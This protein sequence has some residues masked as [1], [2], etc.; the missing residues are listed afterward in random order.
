MDT[1]EIDALRQELAATTEALV[2]ARERIPDQDESVT[3]HVKIPAQR[4][5]HRWKKN[6]FYGTE[7]A[8]REAARLAAAAH[9]KARIVERRSFI[10]ERLL[11]TVTAQ[12]IEARRAE[13]LG[14]VEDESAVPQGCTQPSGKS[15]ENSGK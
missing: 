10:R 1:N 15:V 7:E 3:Y 4:G 5:W 6:S 11:E 12:A 8:A 2:E 13:T 14:S 9:S